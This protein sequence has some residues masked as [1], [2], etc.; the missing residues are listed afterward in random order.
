[1]HSEHFRVLTNPT[2]QALSSQTSDSNNQRQNDRPVHTTCTFIGA[3]KKS[4]VFPFYRTVTVFI[5]KLQ[6]YQ[7]MWLSGNLCYQTAGSILTLN[8]QDINPTEGW[9]HQNNNNKNLHPILLWLLLALSPPTPLPSPLLCT[10]DGIAALP[11]IICAVAT[12]EVL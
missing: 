1:M 11:S 3:L 8:E 6:A 2:P 10:Q 9:C 7:D 5:Q 4:L 12:C